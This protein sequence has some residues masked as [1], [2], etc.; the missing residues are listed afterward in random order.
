MAVKKKSAAKSKPVKKTPAT[1]GSRY[2]NLGKL[3]ALLKT[4][5]PNRRSGAYDVFDVLWLANQIGVTDEAI[6]YW[7]REESMPMK[8][9][10]AI[11]AVKGCKISLGKLLPFVR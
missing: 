9:A 6:Y 2:R 11:V 10:R 3:H 4:A 7:F 1:K 5:F 8:R